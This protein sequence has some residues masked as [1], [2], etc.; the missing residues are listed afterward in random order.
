MLTMS[1]RTLVILSLAGG[2]IGLAFVVAAAAATVDAPAPQTV[3]IPWGDWIAATLIGARDLATVLLAGVVA[4]VAPAWAQQ[5]TTNEVLGRAIDY[6][7]AMASGVV[8]GKTATITQTN[9]A[10]FY[11]EKYVVENAPALAKKLADTL[12]PKLL[13]RASDAGIIPPEAGAATLA[14]K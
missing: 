2:F 12:K 1:N 11:A 4:R 9:E 14:A 10:L 5:Y 3:T 7:I 13:A 6:G 8:K